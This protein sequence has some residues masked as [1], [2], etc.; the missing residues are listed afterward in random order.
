MDV[1]RAFFYSGEFIN[2][3]PAL[4]ASNRGTDSYN[5]EFVRHCYFKYLRRTKDPEIEDPGGFT[6]WVNKLNA[7][8]PTMGDG[9]YSEMIK[10]FIAS[11]EYRNRPFEPLW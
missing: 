2:L 1:S 4:A 9:A 5:R 7:Q 8:F 3:V 11:S 6:F 10:A